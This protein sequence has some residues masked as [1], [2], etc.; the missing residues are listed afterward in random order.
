MVV[1][2]SKIPDIEIP[3]IGIFQYVFS[4]PNNISENKAIFIDYKTDKRLTF[5]GLKSDSK[6]FAAGLQDKLNFK[7]GDVLSIL[8]PNQIDYA[9][10]I[11]GTLVAGGIVSPSNPMSTVKD[12][13]IQ[14]KDSGASVIIVHPLFLSVA[15]NAAKEANIPESKIF[16]FGDEKI[17]KILPYNSLFGEREAIPIEYTPEEVKT[18]TA[19]LC[20]SSGTTGIPKGV[21]STHHNMVANVMQILSIEKDAHPEIV[22]VGVLP[23]YHIYGLSVLMHFIIVLGASC[24]VIPK[25]DFETFCRIIQDYK[26]GIAHIV[27]PIILALVKHPKVKEYDFSSLKLVISGAAALSKELSESFYNVHKIKIK[28]GYG[29][30]ETSPVN[31]LCFT[32]NIVPGSCGILLP[33]IECK[34]IDENGQEVGYNTPGEL[35]IRGPNVMKGYLNNKEATDAVFDEDGYFHTGDIALVDENEYFYIVDRV[36]ELIKYKGFQVAPAELEAILIS[37]PSISDAAVIGIYSEEDVTEY[38]VA[39]VVTKQQ[40][41][42]TIEFSGEIRKF[43]DSQVAPHKKLRGGVIF[44]DQI[45][46]SASGKILRRKLREIHSTNIQLL[47]L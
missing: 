7:R 8:S 44:V 29:L 34:L 1:F 42:H 10:V 19:Y 15:I 2:R 43:V 6:K 35:C 14:L 18:T 32:E 36:K 27:P 12:Y 31:H 26:V 9:T 46:K 41:Q 38:P 25:F 37:H 40:S 20:Y 47:K 23:F 28:Q 11:F 3:P 45:P 16:L 5:A 4:N 30:T 39:Y 33:N 24:V 17:N 21:E 13:T 22:Y